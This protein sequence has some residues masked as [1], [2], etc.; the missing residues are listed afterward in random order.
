MDAGR[1]REL[2]AKVYAGERLTREDGVALYGSDDLAWLGRLAHRRRTELNGERVMFNVNRHLN[3]TNVCAAS[4]AYCSF[5]RE[6]DENPPSSG[7]ALGL[8]EVVRTAREM[9]GEQLSELHLVDGLR[10][11]LPLSRYA[12]ALRELTA[13]LPG[14]E[15]LAFN[16]T[17]IQRL[18]QISGRSAGEILDELRD[19]GLESLTGGGSEIFDRDD[20]RWDDWA[21]IHRVAH[22]KGMKTPATMLYGPRDEPRRRVDHVLRLRELQDETGGF[23]VLIPVRDE[24]GTAPAESLK[25]FAV[26]RLLFDNVPHLKSI[27]AM[28]GP[29]VAQLTL[30]FGADDLD[31]SVVTAEATPHSMHRDDVLELIWDAGFQ[32]VERNSRYEVVRE[33][34]PAPSLASRR[35]EPATVWA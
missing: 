9:A 35:A 20:N 28:H 30:N 23:A 12:E 6:S 3:L 1:K 27:W 25:T 13:A 19:A 33:H 7:G 17:E 15:L 21:R 4:C 8:D 24:G 26:S 2:E 16:A 18:E 22:E 14:V 32:P 5:S 29:S 34:E 10:L 11:A 31:G